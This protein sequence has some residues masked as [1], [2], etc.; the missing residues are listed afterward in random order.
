MAANIAG[1]VG[2]G[3]TGACS[4]FS[5]LFSQY[6]WDVRTAIAI[7]MAESGGDTNIVSP[8]DDHGLMQINHG[9]AIYGSGIYDPATNI[10]IAFQEKYQKG[11]W[12]HWTVYKTGAYLKYLS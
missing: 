8:T 2:G 6:G 1:R 5:G 4:R 10:R 3:S 7:C 12:S 11:G 9:L